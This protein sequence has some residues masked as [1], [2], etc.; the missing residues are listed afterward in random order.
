MTKS[1]VGVIHPTND[2]SAKLLL[3]NRKMKLFKAE[4]LKALN[5]DNFR[6]FC[7]QYA[8]YGIPTVELIDFLKAVI[9]GRSAIEIG[10]GCGDFG[11]HLNIQRTDSCLQRDNPDVYAQ[12]K[13]MGQPIIKYPKDV[14]KIDALEAIEKYKPQV[15]FASWI[16]PYSEKEMPYGSSP[17]GIKE[18]EILDLVE[19]FIIVG[20]MDV[21]FGKPIR[22][23]KHDVIKADW[24]VSR[25]K[26]QENNC[27]FLWDK[28]R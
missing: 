9:D 11:Y 23:H 24:I 19:T 14:E 20:N 10:A 7:H 2:I 8:R 16:I 5:W 1:P 6:F 4:K 17:Y 28:R 18:Q 3:P 27:I 26:N 15:A 25:G 22:Q 21:H 13:A 12:Y